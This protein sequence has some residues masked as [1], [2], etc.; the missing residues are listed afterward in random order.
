[1]TIQHQLDRLFDQSPDSRLVAFG[2]LASGLIL[3]WNAQASCPREV[4]DLLVQ[5]AEDCLGL[6]DPGA[7]PPGVDAAD[8]GASV[9]H[10]T[11]RGTQIFA[12]L[13]SGSTE[14]VCVACAPGANLQPLLAATIAL[15]HRIE[16]DG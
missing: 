10:F 7:L 15:A 12:R 2:D 13:P 8:F 6:L 5:N 16:G 3:N 9:L 11:E 4:L 1:M 14:I